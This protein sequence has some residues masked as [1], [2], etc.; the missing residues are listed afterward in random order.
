MSTAITWRPE[1]LLTS[2]KA[3]NLLRDEAFES[4]LSS[5]KDVALE[6]LNAVESLKGATAGRGSRS[7]NL[8]GEVRGFETDL[9]QAALVTTGGKQLRAAR[10]PRL[11][12]TTLTAKIK[13]DCTSIVP[14]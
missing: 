1:D 3:T 12:H 10:L 4:R 11:K 2:P 14:F 6:L 8:Q 9:V 5:L 7:L 13:R